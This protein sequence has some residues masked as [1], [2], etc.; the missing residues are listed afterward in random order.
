MNN[1]K[2]TSNKDNRDRGGGPESSQIHIGIVCS[3]KDNFGFIQ[4]YAPSWGHGGTYFSLSLSVC[5]CV[6]VCSYFLNINIY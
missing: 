1:R 5:V 6:C 2:F 3:L 4:P